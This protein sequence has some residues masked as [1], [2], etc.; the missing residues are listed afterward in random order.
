M[1]NL[2]KA[3]QGGLV[4]SHLFFVGDLVLFVKADHKNCMAVRDALDT[5][6][7]LLRQKVSHEKFR[8]FFSPNVAVDTRVDLFEILGFWSTPSLG[9]YLGFLIKHSD[10]N[11][12]FGYIIEQMQNCLARW[13]AN[14]LSFAGWMVLTQAVTTTLPNYAMQCVALPSKILSSVD[15]I[16]WNFLWGSTESKKN[17]HLIS[18]KKFTRPKKEAGLG[19][20]A[21]K[22]KK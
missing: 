16:N 7:S 13:N 11:Q 12:D 5:F 17:I 3:S 1:W 14:L 21:A 20:Q 15:R 8:V 6:C 9:K 18:W 4:F 22:E 10:I 2:V 19:I